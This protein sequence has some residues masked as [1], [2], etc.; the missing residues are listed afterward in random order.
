VNDPVDRLI[1]E[2]AALDR[3][4]SR[5]VVLSVAGHLLLAAAAF[6]GSFLAPKK[7]L[8]DIVQIHVIE[9]PRGGGGSPS[10]G[11]PAPAPPKP[12]KQPEPPKAEPPKK[13]EIIKPPNEEPKKGVPLEDSKKKKAMATPTTAPAASGSTGGLSK[14]AAD[15]LG[16][17]IGRVGPGVLDGSDLSG[18]W[19]MG[20]VVQ[21]ILM[22]WRSRIH[23]DLNTPIVV[24]FTILADGS[25]TDVQV[26]QSSGASLLDMAAQSAIQSAA[27]FKPLPKHYD[28]TAD[29]YCNA[30]RC[31][32]QARFTR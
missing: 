5:G 19:Y 9:L 32:R 26:V 20:S 21:R 7:P 27:P 11:E 25:V 23:Q 12:D 24:R 18:D 22:I 28:E 10:G 1:S 29:E 31:T 4:F 8:I 17:G 16:L 15:V 30:T 6:A 13:K 3:G 14:T 2:R